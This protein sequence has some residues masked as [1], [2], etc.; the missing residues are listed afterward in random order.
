VSATNKS[1][2][3][4]RDSKTTAH[5]NARKHQRV[6]TSAS[7]R[8]GPY[9]EANYSSITPRKKLAAYSPPHAAGKG[10][11]KYPWILVK[12]ESIANAGR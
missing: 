9:A 3:T 6:F 12:V 2:R 5:V 7:L 1:A 11:R 4:G 10:I 8:V